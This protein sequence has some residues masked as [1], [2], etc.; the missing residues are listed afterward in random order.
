MGT[1]KAED[2]YAT[3]H[4]LRRSFG[5]RWA[6]RVMPAV[7][8]ELM[9]HSSINTTMGYY[10]EQAADDVGDIL[11]SA[12]GNTL[13]NTG[14]KSAATGKVAQRRKAGTIRR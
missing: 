4:D 1:N 13:V 14:P 8:K 11:R 7:L 5:T 10:V 3:A 12:L 6:K 9:R 2:Q